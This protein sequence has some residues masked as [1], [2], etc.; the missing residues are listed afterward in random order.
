MRWPF[1]QVMPDNSIGIFANQW[2]PKGELVCIHGRVI[3]SGLFY[4]GEDLLS[5]SQF[6]TEVSLINP[7]LPASQ[8]PEII[9]EKTKPF[10]DKTLT[11]W[12]AY[13]KLSAQCRGF[14]LTWLASE[15]SARYI[16]EEY[17]Y[18]YFAGLERRIAEI[19]LFP[20]GLKEETAPILDEVMRIYE[21]LGE[22]PKFRENLDK[23]IKLL[24]FINPDAHYSI[25]SNAKLSKDL[26]TRLKLEYVSRCQHPITPEL[27]FDWFAIISGDVNYKETATSLDLFNQRFYA[28]FG[29]K[30]ILKTDETSF[31]FNYFPISLGVGVIKT[32]V[33]SYFC[34]QAN[35]LFI[36][37]LSELA[38]EI[39]D[40]ISGKPHKKSLIKKQIT[41]KGFD[42]N[43]SRLSEIEKDTQEARNLLSEI[44]I[45]DE[46]KHEGSDPSESSSLKFNE[47]YQEFLY[48]ILGRAS[49]SLRDFCGI[50]E[51]F[52]FFTDGAIE[53]FNEW[54]FDN[55]GEPLLEIDGDI[56]VNLDMIKAL[57]H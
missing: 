3:T 8:K 19:L 51:H 20:D 43:F 40:L 53:F 27:A 17:L 6:G 2:V 7:K 28:Q 22:K 13:S 42:I 36:S 32:E 31:T 39:S 14:Y 24:F 33:K 1:K 57:K 18:L 26:L 44:F 50:C 52:G 11:R 30:H 48:Q 37:Q 41:P 16:L 47:R 56:Y 9:D 38:R 4:L 10:K 55:Y 49:W 21:T 46:N 25:I 23:F 34:E 45:D 12:S 5:I 15:R 29:A 35:Q 54:A